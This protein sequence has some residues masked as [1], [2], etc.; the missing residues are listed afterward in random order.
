MKLKSF[1]LLTRFKGIPVIE[2]GFERRNACLLFLSAI[3]IC[4][5]YILLFLNIIVLNSIIFIALFSDI[6][7]SETKDIPLSKV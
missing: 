4:K 2:S 1:C 5:G 7:L 3:V 6:S